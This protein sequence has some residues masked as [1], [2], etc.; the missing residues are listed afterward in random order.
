MAPVA[1]ERLDLGGK[2]AGQSAQGARGAVVLG[3]V[4]RSCEV[5]GTSHRHHMNRN[6]LRHQHGLDRIPRL[7]ALHHRNHEGQVDLVR[8]PA[9]HACP[10]QLPED[11][12]HG[13]AIACPERV[14]HQ[15]FAEIR[16]GM[17]DG[18]SVRQEPYPRGFGSFGRVR[19]G[20]RGG[21]GEVWNGAH[22]E[23]PWRAP[24]RA[25]RPREGHRSPRG[26]GAIS[27]G[28][29][30]FLDR[31]DGRRVRYGGLT[32]V[33]GLREDEQKPLICPTCQV[34][35]RAAASISYLAW[36]C[37]RCFGCAHQHSWQHMS[38]PLHSDRLDGEAGPCLIRRTEPK[39]R[40]PMTS[41]FVPQITLYRRWLA[42]QR[43]L[44]FADYERLRQWS[45]SDL[46][47]FWRSI[48]DYFDIQSPTPFS[49]VLAS[50]KMPGA[51][52]F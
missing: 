38:S 9:A 49:A 42:E 28:G 6:H 41:P 10:D 33:T 35:V 52:W 30:G 26:T 31:N 24:E 46:D 48:W 44:N 23:T 20:A 19:C 37:F 15:L 27:I 47:A 34:A 36:G 21:P 29:G 39:A 40:A 14:R 5:M 11:A 12:I 43:G 22:V 45:V 4:V 51:V 25:V 1:V 17:L 8:A 18:E 16:I 7:D 2:C 13:F 32:G 3:E 50:R